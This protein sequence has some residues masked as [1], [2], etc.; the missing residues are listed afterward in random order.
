MCDGSNDNDSIHILGCIGV[1]NPIRITGSL[2]ARNT[3]AN[4]EHVRHASASVSRRGLL[5]YAGLAAAAVGSA[6]IATA[7]DQ[8]HPRSSD[9]HYVY[10]GSYTG[11]GKGI[12]VFQKPTHGSGFKPLGLT[13][14]GSNTSFLALHRNHPF[15]HF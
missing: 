13:T 15:L 1:Q 3:M 10:I 5:K 12:Y 9:L 6:N 4:Q 11:N 8:D 14:R 7:E 2:E